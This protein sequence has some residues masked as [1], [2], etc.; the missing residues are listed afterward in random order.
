MDVMDSGDEYDDEPMSTDILLF[1][2][3]GSQSY[4]NVN[5]REARY[6]VRDCI[7]QRQSEWK[8]A[9]KSTRNMG[10]GLHQVFK[11]VVKEIS[12]DLCLGES[13]L[14]IPYFV[15]EPRHFS[16]VTKF[17]DNIIATKKWM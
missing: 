17:A 1:I 15:T 13:G 12:Q 10:K 3:D 5:G 6:K 8:R 7:K 4:P 11:T 16:E 14:E 9:L 2:R